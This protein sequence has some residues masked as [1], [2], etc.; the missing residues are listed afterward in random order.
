[1]HSMKAYQRAFGIEWQDEELTDGSQRN[2]MN[3]N[4]HPRPLVHRS[5]SNTSTKSRE[6]GESKRIANVRERCV[7][8]NKG[9]V[10]NAVWKLRP[11]HISHFH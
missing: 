3:S 9:R 2:L 10:V 8:Q 5:V 4:L 11:C 6:N 7:A 1:M